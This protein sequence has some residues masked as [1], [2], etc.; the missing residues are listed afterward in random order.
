MVI[1]Y[2]YPYVIINWHKCY[3]TNFTSTALDLPVNLERFCFDITKLNAFVITTVQQLNACGETTTELLPNLFKGY[4]AAGDELFV[5]Y[6]TDKQTA[7][8]E[9]QDTTY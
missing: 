1:T 8:D 5:K 3:D 4:M 6:I 2:G 9:G 7:Y